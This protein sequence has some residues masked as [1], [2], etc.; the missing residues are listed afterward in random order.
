MARKLRQAST[1]WMRHTHATHTLNDGA[2]LQIVR[3]NLGHASI[4][5]TSI[6][7]ATEQ[8]DRITAMESFWKKRQGG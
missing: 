5:T 6:Y 3:D 7:V 1:H 4:S 8:R 2:S